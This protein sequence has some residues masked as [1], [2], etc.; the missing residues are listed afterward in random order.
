MFVLLGSP[1]N[2]TDATN[3]VDHVDKN[4][5]VIIS[6]TTQQISK[7]LRRQ[8]SFILITKYTAETS[9]KSWNILY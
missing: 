5:E 3:G 9:I 6:K 8:E 1:D 7:F 2:Q 4:H